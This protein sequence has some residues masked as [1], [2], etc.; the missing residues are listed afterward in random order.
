MRKIFESAAATVMA[1]AVLAAV[2]HWSATRAGAAA[3]WSHVDALASR[4]EPVLW[5]VTL[6]LLG[7]NVVW[8]IVCATVR[9]RRGVDIFAGELQLP[10]MTSVLFTALVISG[11]TSLGAHLAARHSIWAA[12]PCLLGAWLLV[13]AMTAAR[14]RWKRFSGLLG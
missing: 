7:L 13:R 3:A 5:V 6:A 11:A 1:T 4:H 8:W 2:T 10:S 9:R 12:L 14:F